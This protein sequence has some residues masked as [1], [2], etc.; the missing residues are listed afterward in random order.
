[1]CVCVCANRNRWCCRTLSHLTAWCEP[2][3]HFLGGGSEAISAMASA[4]YHCEQTAQPCPHVMNMMI[5]V[6]CGEP[7]SLFSFEETLKCKHMIYIS[8]AVTNFVWSNW[9]ENDIIIPLRSPFPFFFSFWLLGWL[10]MLAYETSSVL[11]LFYR[12]V[13]C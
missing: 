10:Y 4:L 13:F 2:P 8:T 5:H 9:Q 6:L 11:P 12:P 1:M 3:K 7:Q